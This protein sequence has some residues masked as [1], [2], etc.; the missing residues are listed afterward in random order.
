MTN[1]GS[2]SLSLLCLLK[3][4]AD[5]KINFWSV[6]TVSLCY[7][8]Q[9]LQVLFDSS[10][11]AVHRENRLTWPEPR[12]WGSACWEERAV[13]ARFSWE[14]HSSTNDGAESSWQRLKRLSFVSYYKSD[15]DSK[16]LNKYQPNYSVLLKW[17]FR[18]RRMEVDACTLKLLFQIYHKEQSVSVFSHFTNRH[19]PVK[20]N[21]PCFQII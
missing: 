11:V 17:T 12:S 5:L 15:A 1:L 10:L 14:Q 16:S 3:T 9:I 6:N 7:F 4:A 13:N 19:C 20:T 21:Q 2:K 8:F 18:L